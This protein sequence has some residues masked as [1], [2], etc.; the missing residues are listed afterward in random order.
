MDMNGIYLQKN[1]PHIFGILFYRGALC[2]ALSLNVSCSFQPVVVVR[3][4]G[5]GSS[6]M[7]VVLPNSSADISTI[8][9][10]FALLAIFINGAGIETPDK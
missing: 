8:L 9:V 4:K 3:I 1:P 2:D 10:V 6:C 5:T 7:R